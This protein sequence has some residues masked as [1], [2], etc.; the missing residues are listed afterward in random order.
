MSPFK[1]ESTSTPKSSRVPFRDSNIEV[2][3][4]R[5]RLASPNTSVASTE[6][7]KE[8]ND[9]A[10]GLMNTTNNSSPTGT[11]SLRSGTSSSK[12][13]STQSSP[14]SGAACKSPDIAELDQQLQSTHI[15]SLNE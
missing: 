5:R 13:S 3:N 6:D 10:I 2:N 8:N 11:S 4:I 15:S 1:A 14:D 12:G 9:S 7:N